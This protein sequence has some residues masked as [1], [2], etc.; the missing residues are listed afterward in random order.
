M[1]LQR[2][3][4]PLI[5]KYGQINYNKYIMEMNDSQRLEKDN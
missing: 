5:K 2:S 4:H 1:N 3:P